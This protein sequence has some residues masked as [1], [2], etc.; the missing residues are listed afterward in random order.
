MEAKLKNKLPQEGTGIS[1]ESLPE[2]PSGSPSYSGGGNI[3]P[4]PLTENCTG[5]GHQVP[6]TANATGNKKLVQQAFHPSLFIQ[7]PCIVTNQRD[8]MNDTNNRT[9]TQQIF[10]KG[11]FET[12]SRTL[13]L[14]DYPNADPNQSSQIIL[15]EPSDG[16]EHDN[17]KEV[18]R[19]KR[20]NSSPENNGAQK[21]T[22]LDSYWLSHSHQTPT[23]NRFSS[24][25]VD[26][27]QAENNNTP[28]NKTNKPPP[29][30]VDKVENIQPLLK[31]LNEHV[32]DMFTLKV[33]TNNQVKIQPKDSET[34][35]T[36]VHQL[37]LRNT[38]F[39]TYKPKNER[40]FKVVLKKMHPSADPEDIKEALEDIGHTST[41]IWN[42]KQKVT[43]KPLPLFIIELKT[44]PN[45]KHIYEVKTLMNCIVS[46]EPPRPKRELPQCAKCQQYGHTKT[47]CRR[48]PKCIKCA[49]DHLSSD[50]LRK[51]RSD[52]VKCVLCDGNHPANYKGCKIYRELQNLKFPKTAERRKTYLSTKDSNATR[53]S[54]NSL[55]KEK[56]NHPYSYKDAVTNKPQSANSTTE[57]TTLSNQNDI[58]EIMSLMKQMMQQLTTLTNLII[59]LTTKLSPSTA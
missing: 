41:N 3:L 30:F 16:S 48:S 4:A 14:G 57:A 12:R 2:Q 39:F 29:I 34:Y 54:H 13:S 59:A 19:K 45:N 24:L 27:E 8:M 51:T 25:E 55:N 23:T 58:H 49:G 31:T 44:K 38:E 21:Q 50:C 17:W 35:R 47:Y 52:S 10:H 36:I 1:G 7:R 53:E 28:S 26:N 40:G 9:L 11:M 42:I 5:T 22:K 20:P 33:L 32:H 15:T 6:A 46:F 18:T 37:E 43:K 56:L